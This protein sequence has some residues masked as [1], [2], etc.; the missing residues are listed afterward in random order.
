MGGSFGRAGGP[1]ANGSRI[2]HRSW[3]GTGFKPDTPGAPVKKVTIVQAALY[4]GAD[5]PNL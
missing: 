3:G 5:F 1:L 4:S 2:D